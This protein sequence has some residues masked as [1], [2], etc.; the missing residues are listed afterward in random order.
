MAIVDELSEIVIAR[1][2]EVVSVFSADPDNAP[3]WYANI[4]SVEWKSEP[5]LRVGSRFA[6]V[7]HFLFRRLAYTYEVVDYAPGERFVMRTADGP[8]PMETT[9][10]WIP[11][12][13]GGT[14][15]ILGNRGSPSGFSFSHLMAPFMARAMRNADRKALARLKELMERVPSA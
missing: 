10:T 12:A 6:F 15:M 13:D 11:A 9:Y 5:P 2:R 4:K 8:Y 14:R 3:K 1:P 7:A